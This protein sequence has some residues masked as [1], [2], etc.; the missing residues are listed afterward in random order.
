VLTIRFRNVRVFRENGLIRGS[1]ATSRFW[2]LDIA[3]ANRRP[4][5]QSRAGYPAAS[6]Q[7]TVE[8]CGLPVWPRAEE[9][10]MTVR[11]GTAEWHGNVESGSGTVTVREDVFK[12]AYSYAAQLGARVACIDQ[13][14]ELGESD[15]R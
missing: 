13:A 12:G 14:P 10:M 8:L 9:A 2:S 3:T 11:S 15:L 4:P 1:V 7:R 6:F 5:V